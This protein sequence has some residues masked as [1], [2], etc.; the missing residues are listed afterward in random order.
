[1]LSAHEIGV[2]H[3]LDELTQLTRYST[4]SISAQLRHLRR[5]GFTLEKR[6]RIAAADGMLWEYQLHG[7][8]TRPDAIASY[9]AMRDSQPSVKEQRAFQHRSYRT[10]N[11]IRSTSI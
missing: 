7:H 2:W 3:T 11:N 9:D 4:P 1:M 10:R 8:A 6:V 5:M